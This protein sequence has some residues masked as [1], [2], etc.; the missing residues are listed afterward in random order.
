M[1]VCLSVCLCVCVCVH[2]YDARRGLSVVLQLVAL[3]PPSTSFCFT[4]K[5]TWYSSLIWTS[6]R[7][8]FLILFIFSLNWSTSKTKRCWVRDPPAGLRLPVLSNSAST[9]KPIQSYDYTQFSLLGGGGAYFTWH[10]LESC[11]CVCE[12]FFKALISSFLSRKSQ[13][14]VTSGT[15]RI[16]SEIPAKP[17][18]LYAL[19]HGVPP[20]PLKMSAVMKSVSS[21]LLQRT[22]LKLGFKLFL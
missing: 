4:E 22:L 19:K 20:P 15:E 16:K 5:Q 17:G 14:A 10:T 8:V 18:A 12:S 9:R 21:Q 13:S 11:V 1:C 3:S 7:F 6:Q 2:A